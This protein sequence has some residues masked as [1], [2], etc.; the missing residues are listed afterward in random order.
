MDDGE[1]SMEAAKRSELERVSL[2]DLFQLWLYLPSGTRNEARNKWVSEYTCHLRTGSHTL[3][4]L[5]FMNALDGRSHYG[6]SV[7]IFPS[8]ISLINEI[9]PETA[10]IRTKFANQLGNKAPIKMPRIFGGTFEEEVAFLNEKCSHYVENL[11]LSQQVYCPILAP[12]VRGNK[13]NIFI[14]KY[15]LIHLCEDFTNEIGDLF[16][17]LIFL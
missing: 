16:E 3:T 2:D 10:T 15:V 14:A 4:N 11:S 5:A 17:K 13:I 9:A 6:Y 8:I 7:V 1:Q 12:L